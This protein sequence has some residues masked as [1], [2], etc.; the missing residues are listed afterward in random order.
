MNC[1]GKRE[2]RE[3][4]FTG[5]L[6]HNVKSPRAVVIGATKV[7]HIYFRPPKVQSSLPQRRPIPK[8]PHQRPTPH[9]PRIPKP[10]S[11]LPHIPTL[12]R[13]D[14][15][16]LDPQHLHTQATLPIQPSSS[17]NKSQAHPLRICSP[18]YSRL[19]LHHLESLHN[20]RPSQ[21]RSAQDSSCP[22]RR[23]ARPSSTASP[24]RRDR[25]RHC[26]RFRDASLPSISNRS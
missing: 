7:K 1:R 18:F 20:A 14:S 24:A 10:T 17:R 4:S 13:K 19:P 26:I 12:R 11:L 2:G 22:P 5:S 25:D 8:I 3:R 16:P 9:A 6:L 15:R 23:P 21:R